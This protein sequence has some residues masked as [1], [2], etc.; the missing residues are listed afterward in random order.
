MAAGVPAQ[1]TAATLDVHA[2]P[3]GSLPPIPFAPSDGAA[4]LV[5]EPASALTTPTRTVKRALDLVGATVGMVL[6]APLLLIIAAAIKI[7]SPGPV[8]FRQRR[9]G[10]DGVPFVMLKFRSMVLGAAE[11]Q[12]GLRHL[13]EADGVFKIARDPR[14]TRVGRLLRALYLDELPQ[15]L[16]VALGEMSLVGPRPLPLAEDARVTGWGR[17]RLEIRPGITGVW[18]VRGSSR[19]PLSEMVRIDYEYVTELSLKE[20]VRIMVLTI[21]Q[22]LRH[23]G[24]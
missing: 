21:P 17:R 19:V 12:E 10:R 1:A 2:G 11:Q 22:I 18:Q 4:V 3:L 14:L 23:R 24:L 5:A 20:D 13:S 6:L 9:I 15:L 8:L 7:D 16:N